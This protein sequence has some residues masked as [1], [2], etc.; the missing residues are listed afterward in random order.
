MLSL[1][2]SGEGGCECNLVDHMTDLQHA[3]S[4]IDVIDD[5]GRVLRYYQGNGMQRVF[6]ADGWERETRR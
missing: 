5:R 1:S 2:S 4:A 3:L 6:E